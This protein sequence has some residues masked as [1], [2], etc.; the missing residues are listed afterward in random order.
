MCSKHLG[1]N[2]DGLQN[3]NPTDHLLDLLKRKVRA[4]SLQFNLMALTRVIYQ[5]CAAIPQQ[6]IRR[7]SLSMS[8]WYLAVDATPGGCTSFETKLRRDLILQFLF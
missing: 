2:S 3:L 8:T 5:L 6:C 7:H 1:K 4:Q